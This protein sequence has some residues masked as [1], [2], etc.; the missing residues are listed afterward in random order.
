MS[1]VSE[2]SV[3]CQRFFLSSWTIIS[4]MSPVW[5]QSH[6]QLDIFEGVGTGGGLPGRWTEVGDLL[7]WRRSDFVRWGCCL[8]IAR[9][10]KHQQIP[11][12]KGDIGTKEYN[13]QQKTQNKFVRREMQKKSNS[14]TR[15]K[16]GANEGRRQGYDHAGNRA[17]KWWKSQGGKGKKSEKEKSSHGS[18][19]YSMENPAPCIHHPSH[20]CNKVL[21][22]K[23]K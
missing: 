21:S 22:S 12:E 11:G 20:A 5:P 18:Q 3:T 9:Q 23:E 16:T 6:P 10:K 19:Q 2:D 15:G 13:G 8:V 7:Y 1:F 14:E 17:R 4:G